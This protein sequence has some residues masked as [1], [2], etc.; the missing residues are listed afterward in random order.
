MNEKKRVENPPKSSKKHQNQKNK[1][2]VTTHKKW[3]YVSK[4][5]I[6]R[7]IRFQPSFCL[8]PRLSIKKVPFLVEKMTPKTTKIARSQE[9]HKNNDT[10][11]TRTNN[12]GI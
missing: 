6:L 8:I 2:L 3:T 9:I 11:P 7:R 4:D 5:D 1:K 12:V 10:P